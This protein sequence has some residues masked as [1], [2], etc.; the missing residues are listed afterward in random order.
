MEMSDVLDN[1][2]KN[3]K[4][5]YSMPLFTMRSFRIM[6]YDDES[7]TYVLKGLAKV[8]RFPGAFVVTGYDGVDSIATIPAKHDKIENE[9]GSVKKTGIQVV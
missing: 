2:S 7:E 3:A 1:G 8:T 6:R 9:N 5:W 4:D